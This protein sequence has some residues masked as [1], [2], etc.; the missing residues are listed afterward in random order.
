M[1]KS[2]VTKRVGKAKS[3]S[4]SSAKQ[5]LLGEKNRGYVFLSHIEMV[6]LLRCVQ[7]GT[8]KEAYEAR[9]KKLEGAVTV[10]PSPLFNYSDV[11]SRE[12]RLA[13]GCGCERRQRSKDTTATKRRCGQRI[14]P[15]DCNGA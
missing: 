11:I 1:T 3:V 5:E 10:S 12:R 13:Q 15:T 14:Q 8:E 2:T 7:I 9:V 4:T 6:H